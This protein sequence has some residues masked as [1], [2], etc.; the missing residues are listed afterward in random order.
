M[1]LPEIEATEDLKYPCNDPENSIEFEN[2]SAYWATQDFN[3]QI[4]KQ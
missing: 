2:F 1:E 4:F 3:S